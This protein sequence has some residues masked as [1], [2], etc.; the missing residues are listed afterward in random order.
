MSKGKTTKSDPKKIEAIKFAEDF[1]DKKTS[2]EIIADSDS[3]KNITSNKIDKNTIAHLIAHYTDKHKGNKVALEESLDKLA[4]LTAVTKGL[5]THDE[6]K[7][8]VAIYE[9]GI[10]RLEVQQKIDGNDKLQ[11]FTKA[12]E[13]HV[14]TTTRKENKADDTNWQNRRF[15]SLSRFILLNSQCAAVCYDGEQI[16]V[17]FNE[18]NYSSKKA[19]NQAMNETLDHTKEVFNY[20]K[21]YAEYANLPQKNKMILLRHII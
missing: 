1:L 6:L 17:A 2:E 14:N 11:K 3:I 12:F 18:L 13:Y 8:R 9:E 15:D 20:L 4:A 16:L 7:S 21:T 19:N 5:H 10:K